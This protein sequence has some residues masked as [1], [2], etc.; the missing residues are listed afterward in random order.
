M[1]RDRHTAQLA[2]YRR[3]RIKV[4]YC[5][6]VLRPSPTP[7]VAMSLSTSWAALAVTAVFAWIVKTC[8]SQVRRK[9]RL[10]PGPKPIPII[11]NVLDMPRR[12]FGREFAE[13]SKKHGMPSLRCF[14]IDH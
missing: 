6:R 4:S 13:L 1:C 10:P 2:C 14:M 11:G 9:A 7:T 8:F 12:H 3:G 5:G